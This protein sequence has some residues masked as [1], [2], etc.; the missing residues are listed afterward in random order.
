MTSHYNPAKRPV[1]TPFIATAQQIRKQYISAKSKSPP[2]KAPTTM[3]SD[4]S[5]T[6][7]GEDSK[8]SLRGISPALY[9]PASAV[10]KLLASTKHA[11]F[12]K[13]SV[14]P[15]QPSRRDAT[16]QKKDEGEAKLSKKQQ[17]RLP[18]N[19]Q[20]SKKNLTRSM[21]EEGSEDFT[22]IE[23]HLQEDTRI[24][25]RQAVASSLNNVSQSLQLR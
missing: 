11:P 21:I 5:A 24:S 8:Q 4:Y 20:S 16:A 2:S 23:E 3:Q 13:V 6:V 22:N 15:L 19:E 7:P 12:Q 17:M 9:V 25:C 10:S 1:G 14:P 18:T